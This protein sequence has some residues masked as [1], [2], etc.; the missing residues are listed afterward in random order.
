[1]LR[2]LQFY[3]SRELIKTFALTAVGLTLTFSLTGGA[4]N[5]MRADVLNAV[6]VLRLLGFVLPLALTLTLPV[7]ALFSCAMVY[8]RLAAD[9]EF[10]ACRASGI[11]IHRL[12]APAFGL[13][14]LT[15]IFTFIFANFIL[16]TSIR[17]MEAL[18]ARDLQKIIVAALNMQGYFKYGSLALHA[19][20]PPH[21][22]QGPDGTTVQIDSAAFMQIEGENLLRAGTTEQV[23]VNF[24]SD[25]ETGDPVAEAAM[26]DIRAYDFEQKRLYVTAYQ[27]ID[28]IAVPMFTE[29]KTK[30][31]D[32][33]ELLRF[34]REPLEFLPIQR[35]LTRLR[36]QVR[37]AAFYAYAVD[38]LTGPERVLRLGEF[39]GR[40]KYQIRAKTA[41]HDPLDFRPQLDGV[42]IIEA[43]DGYQREWSSERCSLRVSRGIGSVPYIVQ[44]RVAG[45]VRLLN[46]LDPENKRVE[47]PDTNLEAAPLPQNILDWEARVSDLDLLGITQEHIRMAAEGQLP[48]EPPPA[49]FKLG[50][51]VENARIS[52]LAALAEQSLEI[53]GV[54]HS[55]VAFS[56][57]ALVMLVL[58]AALAIIFRGGQLL[59]AF[60]ISFIPGLVVVVLNITGRQMSEKAE[61]HLA[62]LAIIW[63]GIALLALAD[64]VVL[65]KFLK[66]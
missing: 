22:E 50:E 46:P 2:T 41:F 20:R 40:P 11:N 36:G 5:M 15:G 12:L 62:G 6:Q 32:L 24:R 51:R 42:T 14:I 33:S 28:P 49:K 63:S 45:Q 56:A 4:L 57:A 60:I 3:I 25:P 1:M 39:N 52:T 58:A 55:R 21:S 61:Y 37:E 54:I 59:T 65:S 30:W 64:V 31:L 35:Q 38:Q 44:I 19:G 34:R 16:P 23:Q 13:S 10:D 27:P 8:G 47:K 43:M 53:V 66:R 48:S 7:A 17:N 26:H 29:T 18:I 9:N